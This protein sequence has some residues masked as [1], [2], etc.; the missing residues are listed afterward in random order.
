MGRVFQD[1]DL[2]FC[3]ASIIRE[4]IEEEK[5]DD[6]EPTAIPVPQLKIGPDGQIILDPQSLVSEEFAHVETSNTHPS[7]IPIK[8]VNK[9]RSLP[10]NFKEIKINN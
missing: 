10:L 8:G 4:K 6:V 2:W 5:V 3:V 9:D 1:N 7:V